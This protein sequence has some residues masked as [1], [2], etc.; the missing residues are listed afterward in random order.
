MTNMFPNIII[1]MTEIY[2]E[3]IPE[4]DY[5]LVKKSIFSGYLPQSQ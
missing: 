2:Q 5:S 1:M 4:S 3:K